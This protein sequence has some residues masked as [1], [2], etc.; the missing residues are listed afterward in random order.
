MLLGELAHR[1]EV[2]ALAWHVDYWN[3]PAWG[4]P[5][6]T[7]FA[8]GRQRAYAA[9]LHTDVYTPAL[10]VNGAAMVVGSDRPAVAAAMSGVPAAALPVTL[11]RGASGLSV[12][13][14]APSQPLA[15]LLV[16]YDPKRVRAIGGGEN[17]GRRLTEYH[18]VRQ[19]VPFDVPARSAGP[20]RLP[21][22]AP[23]R[24]VVLILQ[25][26]DLRVRGA[27]H[28]PPGGGPDVML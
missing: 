6:A 12:A 8:T 21:A 15:G 27:A 5:Y 17:D 25:S 18:I 23:G 7:R 24:G 2:V 20:L 14:A 28:L 10:V 11:R 13:I 1:P 3:G 9:R 4:D 19:V 26:E 22:Q 16:A